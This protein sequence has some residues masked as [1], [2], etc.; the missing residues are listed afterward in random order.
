VHGQAE[1]GNEA[2]I[3]LVILGPEQLTLGKTLDPGRIDDTDR[4]TGIVQVQGQ[5]IAI[6]PR[7]LEAGMK[8][9]H[10]LPPESLRQGLKAL[11]AVLADLVFQLPSD[12]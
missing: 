6:A 1:A 3:N 5:L 4:V 8:A 7:G 2:G 12:E 10:P 9:I 11:R